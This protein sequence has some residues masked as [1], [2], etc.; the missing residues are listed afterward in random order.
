MFRVIKWYLV[1]GVLEFR[2]APY[3]LISL[4]LLFRRDQRGFALMLPDLGISRDAEV[5][6]GI[7]H[8]LSLHH[9]DLT[10]LD[11]LKC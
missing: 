11:Y 4:R 5:L 2:D 1:W 9:D 7:G 10:S 3:P 8:L 6:L